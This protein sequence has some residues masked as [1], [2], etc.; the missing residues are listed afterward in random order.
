MDTAAREKPH[1]YSN[2]EA[3]YP[4]LLLT[5]QGLRQG[6]THIINTFG[7]LIRCQQPLRLNEIASIS[8]EF[9]ENEPLRVEAQA[10]WLE[11]NGPDDSNQITPRGMVVRFMNL[12][13]LDQQRLRNVIAEHYTRKMGRVAEEKQNALTTI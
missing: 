2:V 8:I 7:A 6:E 3:R 5:A 10:V 11:Y 12:S 1:Q 13:S 4:V 9:S